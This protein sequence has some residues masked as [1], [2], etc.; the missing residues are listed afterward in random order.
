[1]LSAWFLERE[2]P[3]AIRLPAYQSLKKVPRKLAVAVPIIAARRN[4]LSKVREKR[5]AL[6]GITPD[7]PAL[8]S[9]RVWGL[10]GTCALASSTMPVSSFGP[11]S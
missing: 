10:G 3:L 8:R 4:L 9:P 5:F 7:R 2:T 6:A 1:M 11:G